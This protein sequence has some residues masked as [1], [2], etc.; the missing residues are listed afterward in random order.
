[1]KRSAKARPCSRWHDVRRVV[2]RAA[3]ALGLLLVLT[4][5]PPADA[6]V[7]ESPSSA[8]PLVFPPVTNG[9]AE[10]A[11]PDYYPLSVA[12]RW[13]YDMKPHEDGAV[14]T[15]TVTV[16]E[17]NWENGAWHY[18][19]RESDPI[20]DATTYLRKDASGASITSRVERGGPFG[21]LR[22]MFQPDL[23]VLRFPLEPGA[24]WKGKLRV[25]TGLFG[26]SLRVACWVEGKETIRVPAGSFDC[27]RIR[28]ERKW[29]L[30]KPEIV[31]AWYAPRVG[32]IKYEGGR[33]TRVLRC[34]DIRGV[35]SDEAPTAEPRCSQVS[36]DD[37]VKQEE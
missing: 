13:T 21:E 28:I 17:Q 12:A 4:G 31:R 27:L 5:R 11:Q 34:Y 10:T 3:S 25:V 9:L 8:N 30:R 2:T 16:E 20:S 7:S 33:Y 22:T 6:T 24:H 1:M 36:A 14:L 18:V 37:V 26:R 15:Q 23:P 32:L 35:A 29:G 19:V